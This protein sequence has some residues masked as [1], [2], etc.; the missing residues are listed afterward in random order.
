MVYP[1]NIIINDRNWY[2]SRIIESDPVVFQN[3]NYA[4]GDERSVNIVRHRFMQ[5]WARRIIPNSIRQGIGLTD[6]AGASDQVTITQGY[7]IVGGRFLDIPSGTFDASVESLITGTYYLIIRVSSFVESDTRLPNSDTASIVAEILPYTKSHN[8]LVIAKFYYNGSVIS[9]FEDYTA[10]QEWQANV[11]SPVAARP[12]LTTGSDSVLLRAGDAERVNNL[13]IETDRTRFYLGAAFEDQTASTEL[14]LINNNGIL[15][16]R[17]V[18]DTT[19]LGQD[20]LNLIIG[21]SEVITSSRNLTNVGTINTRTLAGNSAGDILTTDATQT[22]T[23]KTL[24]SPIQS[25]GT[26]NSGAAL[27]VDSTEL[28]QLDGVSVGGNTSGDIITTDNTQ[29]LSNKTLTTP[30]ISTLYK[31]TGLT[32]LMTVPNV[33]SDTFTMLTATQT[34]LNKT[35]RTLTIQDSDQTNIISFLAPNNSADRSITIPSNLSAT[36]SDNEIVMT[37]VSQTL[38]NKSI[39]GS[40]INSGQVSVLY[41]GTGVASLTDGGVMLGSGTGAVSVTSRPTAGQLLI[42]QT[43]GDPIPITMSGD[44][45][46]LESGITS[47]AN[48]SHTHDT[49]YYTENELQAFL[50]I[51][52]GNTAWFPLTPSLS[53]THVVFTGTPYF[54]T[55]SVITSSYNIYYEFTGI[56]T[57]KGNKDLYVKNIKVKLRYAT[58]NNYIDSVKLYSY[59]TSTNYIG[60]STS[61][62]TTSGVYTIPTNMQNYDILGADEYFIVSIQTTTNTTESI[63]IGQVFAECYWA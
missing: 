60:G 37:N 30:V 41:G 44:V 1:V 54:I 56:P 50:H 39:S 17:N 62:L 5:D 27:T 22:L 61:N 38:T 63:Q 35:L 8:D 19:Y 53:S 52:S 2:D 26:L 59:G 45:T 40:Q 58:S 47:V 28:N 21:G 42:G 23:N 16:T 4:T 13:N 33:A 32:Q 14:R 6:P 20:M 25:G 18:T 12:G 51:G 15:E 7:A 55:N 11:I 43:S 10:E 49:Q 31:D 3:I 36:S 34:L 9:Q 57:K 24:T 48:D 29:T 46:I